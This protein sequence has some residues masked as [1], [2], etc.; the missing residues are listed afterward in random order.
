M[1]PTPEELKAQL[2]QAQ[3]A[4]NAKKGI[5][6]TVSADEIANPPAKVTPPVPRVNTNDGS[7]TTGLVGNVADNTQGILGAE[8][9]TRK[10]ADEINALLG[11]QT[12][13]GAS[14]R[15]QYGQQYGLPDNLSRLTDIQTQLARRNT[16]SGITKT[17]IA[18][19]AGQTMNQGQ[20]EITQ[21]DREASI[22]DAGLAAEASILSN[23]IETATKIVNSAMS[24]YYADRQLENQNKIQQLEYYSGI[25]DEQTKQLLDKEKRAYEA[26][27]KK[28]ERTLDAV[29]TAVTSGAASPEEIRLLTDPTTS[30][31]ERIGLAQAITG[32]ASKNLY[33]AELYGK[34]LSN[35]VKQKE[36]DALNEPVD[37]TV[38]PPETLK[39]VKGLTDGQRTTITDSRETIN[40]VNRM[41]ALVE[42]AGDMTLLTKATPE[43]REF[44]QL[45][46]NVV[47]KLARK[48]TGAVVGVEEENTFKDILGVGW[49]DLI[50]KDDDEILK[51]LKKFRVPHEE[52]I[53]LN[54]PTGEVRNFLDSSKVSEDD[55]EINAVWGIS[56]STPATPVS[57]YFNK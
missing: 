3:V 9:E 53:N 21:E 19:S 15:E 31:D 12:F 50:A 41:I 16:D 48:R 10:K 20:R 57:S 18:G 25:A 34:Y 39:T 32:R 46:Q 40:E 47:D 26:D 14:Q 13:D 43:G 49:F 29:D 33:D 22:R 42:T 24:D 8:L 35:A 38:I 23:N 45:R 37:T 5:Q 27:Q 6:P 44:L 51:G 56:S 52:A 36:I 2:D 7:R 55:E 11:T 54:D 4:L 28:V 1:Q 17:R 30:D